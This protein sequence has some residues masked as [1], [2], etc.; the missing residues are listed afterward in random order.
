M[1]ALRDFAGGT[2]D[3]LR[4]LGIGTAWSLRKSCVTLGKR[5]KCWEG[6]GVGWWGLPWYFRPLGRSG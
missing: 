4:V 3:S 5:A 1:E 6:V 2:A